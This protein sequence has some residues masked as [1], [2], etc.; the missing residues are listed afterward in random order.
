MISVLGW[1]GWFGWHDYQ[2]LP[3]LQGIDI[4]MVWMVW[5]PGFTLTTRDRYP[6][7]LDGMITRV[8]H[9][10]KGE[11][12]IQILLQQNVCCKKDLSMFLIYKSIPH[13]LGFTLNSYN[14]FPSSI[15]NGNYP[16]FKNPWI[17]R[18]YKPLYHYIIL[19][20]TWKSFKK[21]I[22]FSSNQYYIFKREG[23]VWG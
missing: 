23:E 4:L 9:H 6:H 21:N 18:Y 1:F 19:Y 20:N 10:N 12:S 13:S 2:G 14:S 16:S 22:S 7:G 17:I 3:S 5:F 15:H 11:I 8:Y